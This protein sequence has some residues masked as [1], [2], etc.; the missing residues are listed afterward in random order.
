[1]GCLCVKLTLTYVRVG[2]LAGIWPCGVVTLLSELFIA[3]SKSQVYGALYSFFTEA[4]NAASEIC[5]QVNLKGIQLSH[6]YN[7][8]YI[9]YDDGCHLRKFARNP[10]RSQVTATSKLIAEKDIVIDKMHMKGHV[11]GWCQEHCDPKRKPDLEKVCCF[12][13]I[14]V[15]KNKPEV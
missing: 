1:M 15:L 2:I 12:Y 10:C 5:T 7:T 6:C 13:V 11:D 3:E 8:G 14:Y 4:P 9:C